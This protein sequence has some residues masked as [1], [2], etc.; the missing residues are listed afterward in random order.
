MNEVD[1]AGGVE[2]AVERPEHL[3]PHQLTERKLGS[4]NIYVLKSS[5]AQFGSPEEIEHNLQTLRSNEIGYQNYGFTAEFN[6]QALSLVSQEHDLKGMKE[7]ELVR[8]LCRDTRVIKIPLI[9]GWSANRSMWSMRAGSES[10]ID[11]LMRRCN[12]AGIP[13][14]IINM[15]SNGWGESTLTP[16]M[17]KILKRGPIGWLR[18]RNQLKETA[19][20]FLHKWVQ[21]GDVFTRNTMPGGINFASEATH[22]LLDEVLGVRGPVV[23]IAHSQGDKIIRAYVY[24]ELERMRTK[25][26]DDEHHKSFLGYGLAGA[27][28]ADDIPIDRLPLFRLLNLAQQPTMRRILRSGAAGAIL[29]TIGNLSTAFFGA[30]DV[31]FLKKIA[32]MSM[33]GREIGHALIDQTVSQSIAWSSHNSP[34]FTSTDRPSPF[35]VQRIGKSDKLIP[36]D[37]FL[38]WHNG[39]SFYT[40]PQPVDRLF[41]FSV[42]PVAQY[43]GSHYFFFKPKIQNEILDAIVRDI[44]DQFLDRERRQSVAKQAAEVI[45]EFNGEFQTY[46]EIR[47]VRFVVVPDEHIHGS[48]SDRFH[49][50]RER[51]KDERLPRLCAVTTREMMALRSAWYSLPQFSTLRFAGGTAN[52]ELQK[53]IK[54][55]L[56]KFASEAGNLED[57]DALMTLVDMFPFDLYAQGVRPVA[58]L[59]ADLRSH[60]GAVILSREKEDD[61][62]AF[63]PG[64]SERVVEAMMQYFEAHTT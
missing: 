17:I 29:N 3:P 31:P 15:D 18:E 57:E 30:D 25:K 8:Q 38:E 35:I 60:V 12:E 52:T 63:V 40:K 32:L 14:L 26:Y 28:L 56:L 13:V 58:S 11:G 46:E 23:P 43:E 48:L 42:P 10:W 6:V 22:V 9:H 16:A 53:F 54:N 5:V 36:S 49:G 2:P 47:S 61:K 33:H 51:S 41:M 37:N 62:F 4:E 45:E 50:V 44:E 59:R 55:Q 39:P 24:A 7:Y 1:K 20:D 34:F 21:T 27:E 64:T 19:Q